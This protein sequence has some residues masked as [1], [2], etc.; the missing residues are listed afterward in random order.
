MGVKWSGWSVQLY[1]SK[2]LG[3][4][5][6][7]DPRNPALSATTLNVDCTHVRIEC[8]V[9]ATVESTTRSGER[10]RVAQRIIGGAVSFA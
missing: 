1:L 6:V 10:A 3:S 9:R 5:A 7:R 4:D 2:A 8:D